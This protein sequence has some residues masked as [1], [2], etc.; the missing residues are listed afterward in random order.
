M[1]RRRE[2][3][4]AHTV[5]PGPGTFRGALYGCVVDGGPLRHGVSKIPGTDEVFFCVRCVITPGRTLT[6]AMVHADKR[7]EGA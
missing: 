1:A 7:T 2:P 4:Q 6:R 3:A 5:A